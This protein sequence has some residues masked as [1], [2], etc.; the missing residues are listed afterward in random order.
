[1]FD[2]IIPCIYSHFNKLKITLDSFKHQELIN[3]IIIVLNGINHKKIDNSILSNY[4]NK[5]NLILIN[6]KM[7]PGIAR[8][9]GL[10]HS[11]SDFV[12]FH[13]ADDKAHPDKLLILKNCFNKYNCDHILH[14]IQ[15]IELDFLKYDLDKIKVILTDS[16]IKY[17]Q[18][19][20][21]CDFGD[22]INKRCSH[23]LSAVRKEKII[24]IEWLNIK[25]GEDKDFNLKSLLKGN[26]LILVDAYLSKYDRYKTWIMKRYHPLAW[27]E[28]NNN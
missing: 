26:K 25:S 6:N 24:D 15:P 22:I 9:E 13:D 12:V 18:K 8:Q 28:L 1:M 14:L 3:K 7:L 5:L 17:Y 10:K 4:Q 21:K 16:I 11:K 19:T 20:K 23:G 27:K 2:L